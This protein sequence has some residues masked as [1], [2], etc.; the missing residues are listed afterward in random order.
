M[1][2]YDISQTHSPIF[3]FLYLMMKYEKN[4]K[5]RSKYDLHDIRKIT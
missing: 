5:A 4:K 3:H 2:R 1:T